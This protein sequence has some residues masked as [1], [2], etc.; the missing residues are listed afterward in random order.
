M[1]SRL[2]SGIA[3]LLL[4]SFLPAQSLSLK[5]SVV[6]ADTDAPLSDVS[7]VLSGKGKMAVSGQDGRF[8][9]KELKPGK[10]TLIVSHT[11]Y[12]PLER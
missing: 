12:L 7:L 5:G 4:A 9:I 1:V 3:L 6:D 2:F 11:G 10:Y 8:E